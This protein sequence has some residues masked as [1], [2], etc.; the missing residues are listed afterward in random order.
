MILIFAN[1]IRVHATQKWVATHLLRTTG[2]SVPSFHVVLNFNFLALQK[3]S[4]AT[5]ERDLLSSCKFPGH[6]GVCKCYLS[7]NKV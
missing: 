2:L 4:K 7:Q 3:S 6:L 5:E 1:Q